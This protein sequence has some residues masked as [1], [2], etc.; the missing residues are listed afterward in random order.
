MTEC[1]EIAITLIDGSDTHVHHLRRR[2][3]PEEGP[4]VSVNGLGNRVIVV[5]KIGKTSQAD[6]KPIAGKQVSRA[7]GLGNSEIMVVVPDT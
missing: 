4:H 5:I 6:R 2:S 7:L 1:R 3:L